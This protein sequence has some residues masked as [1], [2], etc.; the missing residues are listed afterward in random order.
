MTGVSRFLEVRP[1][2]L[3]SKREDLSQEGLISLNF[4]YLITAQSSVPG[5][6][7][8]AVAEGFAGI[9]RQGMAIQ[10]TS[11]PLIYI[12]ERIN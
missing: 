7:Q 5:Y 3:Y 6:R 10:I 11:K 8:V 4:T 2:L 12:L 1:D 9:K